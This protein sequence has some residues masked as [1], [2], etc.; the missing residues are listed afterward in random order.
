M[1]MYGT[2][3]ISS[4]GWTENML[5]TYILLKVEGPVAWQLHFRFPPTLIYIMIDFCCQCTV[6]LWISLPAGVKFNIITCLY[7][8]LW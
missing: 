2:S 6:S 8:F 4:A 1:K 7:Y 3:Q 5:S